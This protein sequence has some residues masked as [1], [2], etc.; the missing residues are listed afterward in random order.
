MKQVWEWLQLLYILSEK[1]KNVLDNE[2][3]SGKVF[4]VQNM[5]VNERRLSR[6]IYEGLVSYSKTKS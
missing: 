3:T 2:E 4:F 5:R 1:E 6:Q